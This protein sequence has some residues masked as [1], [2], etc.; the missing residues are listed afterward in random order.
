MTR[1]GTLHLPVNTLAL[2]RGGLVK[3]VML[4][5]NALAASETRDVVIE[6]LGFQPRLEEDVADLVHRGF[7]DARV[8][9]RSILRCFDPAMP[10]PTAVDP[11]AGCVHHG[12][13]GVSRR[14][15][16]RW[17]VRARGARSESSLDETGLT[18]HV[19]TAGRDGARVRREDLGSGDRIVRVVEYQSGHAHPVHRW[20]GR[21]GRCFLS[22]W[23]TDDGRE[24]GTAAI[25]ADSLQTLHDPRALYRLAFE[26]ALGDEVDP[27]LF[28]EFREGLPNIP[29][30]GF[31]D[32]VLAVQHPSLR[33]VAVVHSNHVVQG[34]T[35]MPPRS[36]QNF[37]ALLNGLPK[38]DLLVTATEQ[39]RD[40]IAAQYG[41]PERLAAIPHYAP[42]PPEVTDGEYDSKRFVLVARVHRKK[43]LD[44]AI[45][46]FRLVVDEISDARLEVFGFGYGDE[47]ES[48]MTELIDHL[49]LNDHVEFR[50]FV[51]EVH[52]IYAG[53]CASLHTSESEG[54][55]MAL[56]ESLAHAVPVVAYDVSYGVRDAI[57]DGVDGF[58]VPWGD[59]TALARRLIEL[60]RK[61]KLRARMGA[62][63]PIG[64]SRF[65]RERHVREWQTA[66]DRLPTRP[67]PAP[68]VDA[69]VTRWGV[70]RLHAPFGS[71]VVLRLRG[72][73]AEIIAE[74][75]NGTAV[76]ALPI[77]GTGDILDVFLRAGGHEHRAAFAGG[78]S[79][80]PTWLAYATKYGNLSL[81]KIPAATRPRS[82]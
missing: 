44:E 80:D 56:L 21:D 75:T 79:D 29:G 76:T 25:A 63:G 4:R 5:A 1:P 13:P 78:A 40:D 11:V 70:V 51:E 24:W 67:D 12:V 81:K 68:L 52:L 82:N 19:S 35:E 48:R 26:H 50:G 72:R 16:A 18:R 55:G 47:L 17:P 28:S 45:E 66:L 74:L 60:S 54:F 3:A 49:R 22:V 23:P 43:R 69:R 62:E 58:I 61:P 31:D 42:A 37:S 27:V 8:H 30:R 71:T 65:S 46:A 59:R 10:G 33:R 34:R 38:W 64:A 7:L 14:S 57:R 39:Q 73:S 36:S 41:S 32:V 2:R 6:V 9:V 20:I 53:A 15:L 77:A